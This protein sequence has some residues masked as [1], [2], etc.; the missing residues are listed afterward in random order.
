MDMQLLESNLAERGETRFRAGQVW[1]WASRGA[2]GFT[3][4]TNLPAALRE[5]LERDLPF[6]TLSLQREARASDGTI[7]AL[8]QTADGRPLEAVLMRYR[9]RGTP[10][11]GVTGR[12][13][14]C[15]SSQSG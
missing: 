13:S 11:S 12:R 2:A 1:T 5:G 8:F 15:L 4:M 7:K 14:I 9:D 3:E 10:G 6:S